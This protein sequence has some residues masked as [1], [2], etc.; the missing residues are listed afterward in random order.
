MCILIPFSIWILSDADLSS[1][2]YVSSFS[3]EFSVL[4]E[5]FFFVHRQICH[6]P[7]CYALLSPFY[8][9]RQDELR[10]SNEIDERF[11]VCLHFVTSLLMMLQVSR[12]MTI[13]TYF[14]SFSDDN[15]IMRLTERCVI[16]STQKSVL[17][18]LF[19]VVR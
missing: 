1:P 18:N 15:T 16:L 6:W 19:F 5:H 11:N 4:L 14:V 3:Y 10:L 9:R 13:S 7:R 8:D 12:G 2:F 17:N